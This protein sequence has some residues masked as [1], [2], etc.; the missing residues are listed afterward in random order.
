MICNRWHLTVEVVNEQKN[1][2]P[3]FL[4]HVFKGARASVKCVWCVAVGEG[5]DE[6]LF[7]E[8]G[9]EEGGGTIVSDALSFE[10][11]SVFRSTAGPSSNVR[12]LR[13]AYQL[14]EPQAPR[15]VAPTFLHSL[16]TDFFFLQPKNTRSSP[17][18]TFW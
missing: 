4:S 17:T 14:V 9:A 8:R 13:A 5:I 11:H 10:L 15:V 7:V 16:L 3:R 1:K 2:I 6:S 12:L 18:A